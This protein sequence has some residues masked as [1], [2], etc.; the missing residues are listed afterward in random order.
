[1]FSEWYGY[2][3]IV[4]ARLFQDHQQSSRFLIWIILRW[5]KVLF[6]NFDGLKVTATMSTFVLK[7]KWMWENDYLQNWN[8]YKIL[9]FSRDLTLLVNRTLAKKAVWEFYSIIDKIWGTIG[10]C[11]VHQ[12]SFLITWVKTK[13]SLLTDLLI[14]HRKFTSY[15]VSLIVEAISL[16]I[17]W[18]TN[19]VE[20]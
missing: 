7:K 16:E 9:G 17:A 14:Q 10:H 18:T 19:F 2:G 1:M 11:L 15:L 6:V 3:F 4:L 13:K 12:H 8:S 5:L 20:V